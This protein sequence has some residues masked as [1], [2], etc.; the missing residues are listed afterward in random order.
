[1]EAGD[2]ID[3]KYSVQGR[4]GSGTFSDV[5]VVV[6]PSGR[7]AL[8]L[9]KKGLRGE[10]SSEAISDFKHEFGILK[11]I[12]HPNIGR[13][14]DFGY[15]RFLKQYYF[16]TEL[17]DGQNIL[18]ATVDR[19]VDFILELFVQTLRA[20]SHLH[21]YQVFH[22]DVKAANILVT[23]ENQIKVIDFGLASIDPGGKMIGTP[24]TMA[25]EIIAKERPDGRADLYSL[26]V[27]FYACLTRQN[28]FRGQGVAETLK[29]HQTLIPLPPS[30]LRAGVPPYLDRI[31]LRLLEKNPADR[32]QRAEEVLREI[33]LYVEKKFD[34]ETKETLLAYLPQ[35]GRL[36]GRREEVALF[37]DCLN[38]VFSPASPE[39]L[40]F[41]IVLGDRGCGKSRLLKEFKYQ[42]QLQGRVVHAASAR[43]SQ[44]VSEW[45]TAM[46]QCLDAGGPAVFIVDDL[47]AWG[48]GDERGQ[49]LVGLLARILFV[50][51]NDRL[52]F[53]F[54]GS[55]QGLE[56]LAPSLREVLSRPEMIFRKI[57]P[58]TP[59]EIR[60]YVVSLT[61]IEDPPPS[62]CDGLT[63]RT[64]GNPL[65]VTELLRS[66]I[67]EG[68]LFDPSGRWKKTTFEDLGV[69]FSKAR[70]SGVLEEIL[71][72]RYERLSRPLKELVDRLVIGV[73]VRVGEMRRLLDGVD[74]VPLLEELKTKELVER[75]E[76]GGVYRIKNETLADL[77]YRRLDAPLRRAL[78]DEM[79][80]IFQ[81]PE[82]RLFH[83]IRGSDQRRALGLAR[84]SAETLL[85]E[86]R[87]RE[88]ADLLRFAI[89]LETPKT[90]E[91]EID[92][93][94]KLGEALLISLN[95]PEAL[96]TLGHVEK[97]L[98]GQKDRLENVHGQVDALLR[99]G[100]VYLKVGEVEKSRTSLAEA[101]GL[102]KF[103]KQD[104]VRE[105][106]AENLRGAI[107]VQEGQLEEARE[108]FERTRRLWERELS[109]DEKRK[110][111]NNDLGIVTLLSQQYP[112][113]LQLFSGDLAFYEGLGDQLL[114]A[115]THYNLGQCWLGLSD[116]PKAAASYRTAASLAQPLRN[117]ELLLRSY[118]GLGNVYNLMKNPREAIGHY[119]RGLDLCERTGDLRSHAA[120]LVNIGII[121][122]GEGRF[123]EARRRLEPAIA[124]LK[125]VKKGYAS[126]RQVLA[127][128]LLEEGD[129]AR[130][131][132]RWKDAERLLGESLQISGEEGGRSLRFWILQTMIEL[133]LEKGETA[134]ASN[135]LSSAKEE[136]TSPDRIEKLA[137]LS[138]KVLRATG[139]PPP[140]PT[141]PFKGGV[142]KGGKMTNPYAYILEINKFI[143]A[144]SDLPFVLKTV[145]NYAMELSEAESGLI[146]LLNEQNDLEI[147]AS[148]NV[149]AVD[150]LE[151]VSKTVARRVI[152]RGEL[153]RTAD[154]S[155]DSSLGQEESVARLDLKSILCLPIRSK[156]KTI[157]AVYLDNRI[158][159][160]AF[161]HVDLDLLKA[162]A[163]QAGIAI[164]NAKVLS[165]FEES[166]K[167]LEGKI[168]EIASRLEHYQSLAHLSQREIE[169]KY[170]YKNIVARSKPMLEIFR[171]LDKITDTDLAVFIHGESGTGKELVAR[172]LHFNSGRSKRR[173]VAVNCGA[174]PANLIES[175][176]FGYKAGAFT[177]ATRDKRGLFEE[178]D[179]GTLFLD[180]VADLEIGLQAKLLRAVQEGEFYRVGDNHPMKADVRVVSASNKDIEGLVKEQRFREDLFYRLCQIRIDLPPL[181]ERREDIPLL[182]D[183]FIRQ[184]AGKGMK[185][186]TR[187][188]KSFLEY[189]WPGNIRE[190]ANVVKV[191]VALSEGEVLE[192]DAV[193]SNY[194]IAKYL[195]DASGDTKPSSLAVSPKGISKSV[196]T[197]V[198]IDEKNAY[199]P[200]KSWYDYEKLIIAKA[201]QASGFRAREAA[202]TLGIAVATIYKKIREIGLDRKDHP[203]YRDLFE[204]TP[205]KK[206]KDY[207]RPVFQAALKY[208]G[209]KPYTAISQLKVSQGYFYKVMKEKG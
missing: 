94:L 1:M 173:F 206:L 191:A 149:P 71:L 118:N 110:V 144:E 179:G 47:D 64:D 30:R 50:S 45:M 49:E 121:Q 185:V 75:E 46:R 65:L 116:L 132:K 197:T 202:V 57:V 181:R 171:L 137:S 70:F 176:L 106:V 5:Y 42:A 67:E 31:L 187:L 74:P 199:D 166:K 201:F 36:V 80:R 60:D 33:N 117:T 161:D 53:F 85:G 90:S 38:R 7:S 96:K 175:E 87:G 147:R 29:N 163:E 98:L 113:A 108:L 112:Q 183:F 150:P 105:L 39:N 104:R 192:A 10:T 195:G 27:L 129:I 140:P 207:L 186:A 77:I 177:G 182:T 204:Y 120:I 4:V 145:L 107:L 141:A 188:L 203:L 160:N 100:A 63:A 28:P 101:L 17:I 11:E 109:D 18:D 66:L 56:T 92:L 23:K 9:L 6:G 68:A 84:H 184:E 135:L 69:D 208:S 61:G 136:A 123:E 172:A 143:N 198:P 88:A 153:L 193:P 24:S 35:E 115:R 170:D 111:T 154:A 20:F 16:T 190:L 122:A 162:F 169:T 81:D 21:A 138:D 174:I 164:Q 158:L 72:A 37:A 40:I 146:L 155:E 124:F 55:A 34:L 152:E 93:H 48:E 14:L 82:R 51:P 86:A 43:R 62:L 73:K 15:D 128:A 131:E 2:L 97:L 180:E 99:I 151:T 148:R 25:P 189:E 8:K 119:E 103:L 13:I 19:P 139:A 32:Y 26:G 200:E 127:R 125:S 83:E 41:L 130:Q 12:S 22:F 52:P 156:Q 58:F 142:L 89:E 44:E 194:G 114:L 168:G 95:Y 209:G 133:F 165:S 76:S 54:V 205:G 78:H 79:A 102:L 91:Q 59:V 3:G 167:S 126:D 178:A 159:P 196:A 157:G 134:E